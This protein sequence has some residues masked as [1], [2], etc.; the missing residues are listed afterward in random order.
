MAEEACKLKLWLE[1]VGIRYRWG[2]STKLINPGDSNPRRELGLQDFL[3]CPITFT[4]VP[5]APCL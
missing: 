4:W 3:R 5:S 1:T 2:E